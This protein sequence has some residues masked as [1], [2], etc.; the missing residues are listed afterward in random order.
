M[1]FKRFKA[2]NSLKSLENN[3]ADVRSPS[4]EFIF[5]SLSDD[6]YLNKNV[7]IWIGYISSS[8]FGLEIY[9]E[10]KFDILKGIYIYIYDLKGLKCEMRF[11]FG[12]FDLNIMGNNIN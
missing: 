2:L 4:S 8:C 5:E 3:P 10:E 7:L 11:L 6:C 12:N 1:D 9:P